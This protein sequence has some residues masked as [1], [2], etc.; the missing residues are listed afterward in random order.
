VGAGAGVGLARVR[1]LMRCPSCH[2]TDVETDRVDGGE[3]SQHRY[4]K[5]RACGLFET[6][7][8]PYVD[9]R[10]WRNSEQEAT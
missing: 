5:C 10:R 7:R 6:D 8:E 1:G 9:W 4:W 3:L 2:R